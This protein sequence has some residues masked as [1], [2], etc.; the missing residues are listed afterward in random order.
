MSSKFYVYIYIYLFM[1]KLY[2]QLISVLDLLLYILILDFLLLEHL[3][4]GNNFC[5]KNYTVSI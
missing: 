5:I 4:L 2:M 1:F 3:T